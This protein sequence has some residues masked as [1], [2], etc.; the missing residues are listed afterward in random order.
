LVSRSGEGKTKEWAY[1][2]VLVAG[3]GPEEDLGTWRL[4]A[5]AVAQSSPRE[6]ETA[7]AAVGWGW[8]RPAGE[9][10][11]EEGEGRRCRDNRAPLNT[12][13]PVGIPAQSPP[14]KKKSP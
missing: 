9:C 6:R 4:S 12:A 1:L 13:S 2:A 14:V 7:R 8:R 5:A 3:E 11:G 10:R